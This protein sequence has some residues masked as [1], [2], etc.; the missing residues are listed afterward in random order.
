[1]RTVDYLDACKQKLELSSD[2]QLAKA[3]GLTRSA[4]SAYR[5]NGGTFSPA[6]AKKVAEIL[7]LHPLRVR[8][9]AELERAKTPEDRALWR[10]LAAKI[11][12]VLAVAGAGALLT[13]AGTAEAAGFNKNLFASS[14]GPYYALH[15]IRRW[16]R[17][18]LAAAA[19]ALAAP[20]AIAGE[21]WSSGERALGAAAIGALAIDWGQSRWIQRHPE[22]LFYEKHPFLGS[23]PS[24]GEVDAY[25][26]GAMLG[27]V[28]LADWLSPTWRRRFLAGVTV[29]ELAVVGRNANL[30]IR[31]AW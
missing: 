6:T 21:P 10:E 3:L 31:V 24:V 26:A 13:F 30:G 2:Y 29:V 20:A 23:H 17:R 28:V 5:N 11:G 12:G 1:M 22:A 19:I 7:G 27:T 4:L 8:A 18:M 15:A 14:S 9:D 16:L 25:F